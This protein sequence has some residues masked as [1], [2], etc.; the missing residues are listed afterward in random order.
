MTGGP[1]EHDSATPPATNVEPAPRRSRSRVLVQVIGF[2]I[3][4]GLMAWC[5]SRAL[6]PDNRQHLEKLRDADWRLVAALAGL[7]L[8]SLLINGASFWVVIRP[9]RRI[10]FTSVLAVNAL[11][12]ALASLPFKLSVLCRFIIHH[13]RDGVPLLTI[14]VWMGNALT[15]ILATLVPIVLVS[16]WR[17]QVDTIWFIA[18]SVGVFIATLAV[19]V[20]ARVFSRDA[21]WRWLD[22]RI[23]VPAPAADGSLVPSTPPPGRLRRL[24]ARFDLLPKAREGVWML[25]QPGAVF[26][27]AGL[28]CAD[29]TIQAARFVV[30]AK[31]LGQ[32][33]NPDD[34][35]LA[36]SLY[37][38]VGVL[39]PAG[40]L[41]F[42]E[43][44]VVGAHA[45]T[46]TAAG[47][48]DGSGGG[49]SIIVLTVTAL[50]TLV[51]VGAALVAAI[52]LRL[53]RLLLRTSSAVPASTRS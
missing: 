20:L 45:I 23:G 36:A 16:L 42:R 32:V 24:I 40:S 50:D 11:A 39:S 53:D 44:A 13:R 25:A 14:T 48:P 8:L 37:F 52:Y 5:V 3:G 35:L 18:A 7:S 10:P 41:G 12:T 38:V 29:I 34:A 6:S 43:A 21:V 19:L 4:I 49:D 28:R 30:A 33:M 2:V 17:G 15:I 9:V 46:T 26:G 47:G 27:G 1:P 51:I 31:L 22:R